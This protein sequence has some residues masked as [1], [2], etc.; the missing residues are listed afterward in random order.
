MEALIGSKIY[1][2]RKKEKGRLK[3]KPNS[4]FTM[5]GDTRLSLSLQECQGIHFSFGIVT[6]AEYHIGSSRLKAQGTGLRRARGS[7]GE[8]HTAHLF[9]V[10]V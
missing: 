4:C 9:T 8:E 7:T 3:A 5:R 10:I 2:D 6:E 1:I